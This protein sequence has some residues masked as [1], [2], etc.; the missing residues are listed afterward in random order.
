MTATQRAPKGSIASVIPLRM[1]AKLRRYVE[2]EAKREGVS[3]A[4]W[5]RK[6]CRECVLRRVGQ[7]VQAR[8]ER[9]TSG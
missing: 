9:Q 8:F 1:D 3:L 2:R 6:A 7:R 4:E 5:I